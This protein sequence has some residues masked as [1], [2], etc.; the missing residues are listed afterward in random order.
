MGD[1]MFYSP[2]K[3]ACFAPEFRADYAAAGTWPDDAV[4]IPRELFLIVSNPPAGKMMA[5]GV[6]GLPMLVDRPAP[7]VDE[8][9][10]HI[11]AH[12]DAVKTGGVLV[13]GKWFHTDDSSRIQYLGL[14]KM[15]EKALAAGGNDATPLQ[16]GGTT[17][18]WKTMDG[19]FV[20]MTVGLAQDVIAAVA[21]LDF[22]SFAAAEQHRAA[23]IAS[24]NAAD[25]D[26][27]VGWPASYQPTATQQ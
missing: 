1:N 9:W 10:Q 19:S 11:K 18:Q 21:G 20:P 26:Y 17:I 23:M 15:A 5:P 3:N 6:D 27:S 7:T 2:S 24:G 4:E 16:Y 25:Y 12:R 8:I 22:V 14:D 13:A